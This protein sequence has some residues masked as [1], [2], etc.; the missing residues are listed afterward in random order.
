MSMMFVGQQGPEAQQQLPDSPAPQMTGV[1]NVAP[2]KGTPQNL[3]STSSSPDEQ[4]PHPTAPSG[5]NGSATTAAADQQAE[6]EGTTPGE[7]LKAFTLARVQVNYVELP[8]TVKDNKGQL[9]PGVDWRE[10]R[11]FEN[12]VRQHIAYWTV[13][14]FPIS[15]AFVIDQSLPF[16]VMERVNNSLAA[17]QGAFAPYD[18]LAIFTY[19][20][21]P[22]MR[23]DFTGAQSAR[24]AAVLERSK[25][26]G[27]EA[28]MYYNSGPLSQTTNINGHQFDPN[29]APV[30]NSNSNT[31]TIPKEIHTLNDAIFMAARSLADRPVGRR[32]V[33]YVI[34]DGKEQGSKAKYK[35]VVQ[36][37]QTHNITLYATLVGDS[38]TWGIG[39]LDRYHLPFMMRDNILPR[40]VAETGGQAVSEYRQRGIEQSFQKIAEQ[41]RT[42][43]TI[44]YY[45]HEPFI[46]GKYRSTEVTVS[47]PNLDVITKKG[48]FPTPY[49]IRPKTPTPPAA[50][51]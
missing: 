4:A 48:Y 51:Q 42:Q 45:S 9:V 40:Y 16:N 43:Y 30:R 38:A 34:S 49:D 47:R 35:E 19:N 14:A 23:T 20:N 13:D 7:G 12:G 15:A 18:E 29:T 22:T 5:K 21:G 24:V 41:V 39:F 25:T 27:R 32:R 11:V 44:G 8:F 37:L 2:G 3:P 17:V 31:I 36:Y 1:S 28:P 50:K 26:P 10:V 46:D 33:I 6:P